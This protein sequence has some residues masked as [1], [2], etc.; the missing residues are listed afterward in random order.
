MLYVVWV[1]GSIGFF[2]KVFLNHR[3]DAV[4]TMNYILL[5]W[6]PAAA[7]F[8]LVP[9]T[10]LIWLVVGGLCY[11]IGTFFLK[12]DRKV[13]YFHTVWHVLVIAGTASHYY[14]VVCCLNSLAA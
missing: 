1:M 12:T 5:G 7:T 3:I 10:C 11:T 9:R 13:R 8:V 2:S 14:A 6:V 4:A